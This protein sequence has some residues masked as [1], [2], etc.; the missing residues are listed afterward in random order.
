[1]HFGGVCVPIAAPVSLAP[2]GAFTQWKSN[3]AC[4][5]GPIV[6]GCDPASDAWIFT[7]GC[8]GTP[9]STNNLGLGTCIIPIISVSCSPFQIV[10]GAV[11]GCTTALMNCYNWTS[12]TLT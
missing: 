7:A 11:T 3:N 5:G 2:N 12:I 9:A 4:N 6:L 1:M 8:L 10:L